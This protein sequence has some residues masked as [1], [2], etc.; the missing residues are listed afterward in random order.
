MKK[1]KF[2]SKK[3]QYDT[4][5]I[6][7]ELEKP[8]IEEND[9]KGLAEKTT[10]R[11]FKKKQA[12]KALLILST[13]IVVCFFVWL[14][15]SYLPTSE[16][17]L[18]LKSDSHVEV[19]I[20]KN[21]TVFTPK[22]YTPDTGIILYPEERVDAK[23]YSKMC[24]MIASN[25]YKVV[26]V[27]MPFNFAVFGKNEAKKIIQQNEDIDN[28]VIVGD[29]LGGAVASDYVKSNLNKIRGIV[30]ISSYPSD[31]Y[32]KEVNMNV[33]SIWGS[34]DGVL[35]YQKLIDAKE[36]LPQNTIY[37]EIEGANHSQFADYGT[38]KGDDDALISS[39]EQ[40]LKTVETILEF[41]KDI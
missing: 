18:Y 39:D 36:K 6:T 33:L 31:Y 12:L 34:K 16:A 13:C 4:F 25:G 38:Y 27:D 29:S 30:F 21:I 11:R 32:L 2:K 15:D 41:L 40:K 22:S 1:N 24:N 3:R 9:E 14:S 23:A 19:K 35:K 7:M 37:S 28:W 17:K 8:I 26:A 20:D 10:K 5:S